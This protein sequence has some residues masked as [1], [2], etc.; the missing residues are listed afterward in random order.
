MF[1][2]RKQAS[3]TSLASRP[4]YQYEPLRSAGEIRILILHAA[5]PTSPDLVSCHLE[6][7]S[8]NSGVKYTAVSY[9]WGDLTERRS[10]LCDNSIVHVTVNLYNALRDWRPTDGNIRLW[11][12][13]IC[14]N[15][16]D[17]TE[18][19]GQ[20]G[21]MGKVYSQAERVW[22]WLGERNPTT[23]LAYRLIDEI[24]NHFEL[25]HIDDKY[26]LE[27][28]APWGPELHQN[29]ELW[30]NDHIIAAP[31]AMLKV[32]KE[33]TR[34]SL[35]PG[36]LVD[37]L[38]LNYLFSLP[39]F[40]R[41]WIIQEV[42]LAQEALVFCGVQSIQW[43]RL[44]KVSEVLPTCVANMTLR[45]MPIRFSYHRLLSGLNSNLS[46]TI[47]ETSAN[48]SMLFLLVSTSQFECTDVRD[49]YFA[50]HSLSTEF[51]EADSPLKPDYNLT[52]SDISFRFGKWH[53]VTKRNPAILA[54]VEP[55]APPKSRTPSWVPSFDSISSFIGGDIGEKNHWRCSGD[56]ILDAQVFDAELTLQIKGRTIGFVARVEPDYS[57]VRHQAQELW[58]SI[59]ALNNVSQARLSLST[60]SLQSE[61][62]SRLANLPLIQLLQPAIRFRGMLLDLVGKVHE[63][64]TEIS[65]RMRVALLDTLT[66]DIFDPKSKPDSECS[67]TSLEVLK[68]VLKEILPKKPRPGAELQELMQ[69]PKSRALLDTLT[70]DIFDP[71]L[72]PDSECS[73]TFLEVLG[74]ILQGRP[75]P[76]ADLQEL[77]Q[78]PKFRAL[79]EGLVCQSRRYCATKNDMVAVVPEVS[80]VG[81]KICLFYGCPIPY[82]IRPEKD[83]TYRLVGPCYLHGMMQGEAM[84]MSN[85]DEFFILR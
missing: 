47:A 18:K 12:D 20:V 15:Q 79:Y 26:F 57:A 66:S 17:N 7:V 55:N 83:G 24:Y 72:K 52:L 68:E 38:A 28:L 29:L 73:N 10:I 48:R 40:R 59:P 35:V 53:L 54:L 85:V 36:D 16:K 19:N 77:M 76:G 25:G 5:D 30:R 63:H 50:L 8:L 64:R 13:A 74:E 61:E 69:N 80:D 78:N 14:I 75:R 23:S 2:L 65:P 44:R 3:R 11:A 22:V 62:E 39:W 60:L 84:Q 31:A 42:V 32:V 9:A 6:T 82:V 46:A 43:P 71:K 51:E 67:N 21:I 37:W 58:S 56:S 49:R 41:K 81:D 70:F 1:S 34:D 33:L 45:N 27:A 4:E